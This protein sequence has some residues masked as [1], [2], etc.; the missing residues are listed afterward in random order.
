MRTTASRIS[1]I[2]LIVI[3]V[4]DQERSVAFYEGL[5]SSGATTLR[6]ETGTDGSRSIRRTVRP[7]WSWSHQ[8]LASRRG[9]GLG[10][11]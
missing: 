10:S 5:G 7:V 8:G 6:G 11:S 3:P 2:Q 1:Q 4:S 9:C